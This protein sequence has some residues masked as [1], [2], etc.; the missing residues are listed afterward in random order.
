MAGAQTSTRSH[1]RRETGVQ[2]IAR[3]AD[4]MRALHDAPDG[5]TL[6]ELATEVSLAR[7]TAH[8]IVAALR[9]QGLV[10]APDERGLLRLGPELGRLATAPAVSL[11]RTVR[12]FIER[13]ALDVRETVDL[14]V[15]YG[16]EIRFIDQVAPGRRLRP[17]TVVG[18]MFPAHCT[19]NGKALLAALPDA[20]LEATLPARLKRYT[21]HTIVSRRELI[22]HLEQVRQTG[23][24]LDHEECELGISAVGAVVEDTMGA[25]AAISIAVPS[26]RFSGS[27]PALAK[28]VAGAAR[29]ATAALVS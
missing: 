9:T 17:L 14:A 18:E 24:A 25:R 6:S 7:T 26:E 21:E 12:P 23:V 20:T 15:L 4:I 27:E 10:A 28:A 2:V 8:R 22:V 3:A 11:A 5:L 13:L 19:A 16:Q 29:S 1:A